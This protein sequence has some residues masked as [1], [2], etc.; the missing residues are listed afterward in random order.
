MLIGWN[1][2][3]RFWVNGELDGFKFFDPLQNCAGDSVHAIPN[4]AFG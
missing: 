1:R 4:F 3:I 2:A